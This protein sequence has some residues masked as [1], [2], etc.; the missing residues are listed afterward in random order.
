M[1]KEFK[2]TMGSIESLSR[3]AKKMNNQFNSDLLNDLSGAAV[4]VTGALGTVQTIHHL[5]SSSNDVSDLLA[6]AQA[7]SEAAAVAA[8]SGLSALS[9]S[10]LVRTSLIGAAVGAGTFVVADYLM[11]TDEE[12]KERDVRHYVNRGGQG[13]V[14]GTLVAGAYK[15]LRALQ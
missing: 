5:A 2:Q 14:V 9:G 15:I 3:D 12:R 8:P 13:A 4:G 6:I 7:G 1:T 10:E 11:S